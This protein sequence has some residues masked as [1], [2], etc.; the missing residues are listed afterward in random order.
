MD[1]VI[2]DCKGLNCP[3]PIVNIGRALKKMEVGQS[4]EV[5]A[6]DPAF[7]YDVLAYVKHLNHTLVTIEKGEITKVVIRKEQ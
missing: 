6:D 5:I 4:I 7:E 2:L 3:L 1:K